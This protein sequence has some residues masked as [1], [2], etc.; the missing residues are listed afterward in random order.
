MS[1]ASQLSLTPQQQDLIDRLVSSGRFHGANDVVA[2]GL[3]L[4]EEREKQAADLVAGLEAE[5]D[6]GL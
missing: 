3:R 6:K 5:I 4:L 2:A 1:A